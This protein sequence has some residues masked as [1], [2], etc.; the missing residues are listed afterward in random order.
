MDRWIGGVHLVGR[1]VAW[2]WDDGVEAIVGLRRRLTALRG[3]LLIEG[4]GA[5]VGA[6]AVSFGGGA[7]PSCLWSSCDRSAGQLSNCCGLGPETEGNPDWFAPRTTATGRAEPTPFPR[8]PGRAAP[9]DAARRARKSGE[10]DRPQS[11]SSTQSIARVTA[12]RHLR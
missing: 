12:L 2:R 11:S 8:C 10:R 6:R 1:D 7:G 5:A 9:R 3:Q 4:K